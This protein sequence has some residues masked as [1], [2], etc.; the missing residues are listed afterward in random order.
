MI[1]LNIYLVYSEELENRQS[2]INSAISLVKDICQQK[3]VEMKLHIISEPGKDYINK[4]ISTF[5]SRVN[6][7]KFADGNLYNDLIMPLNVCQISNF[8]KHRYIYKLIMENTKDSDSGN[9]SNSSDTGIK[10]IHMIM[11]DD[12]IILKDYVNNIGML[13]DDLNTPSEDP[14]DDWDILFNCLNVVNNPEKFININQLYNIIISKS[15]YIIKNRKLCEKLYEATNTFKLNIKLTLSKF[16]KDNNYKAISYNKITFIEGSKLGLY[17]S[18]VNPNNYL[19]LNNN[20]ISLKQLSEKKELTEED[21]KNAEKIYSESLNIASIDIQ[22]LMGTIYFNYKDYKK[23]K[24]YMYT[25]LNNLKKC[26]GYSIMKNNEMLNNTINIY[27]Y[28]QDMLAECIQHKPKY[29]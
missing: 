14:N 4:H 23:A 6:Y 24:E 5:N 7:D 3:N 26:K 8:E 27:K 10:E 13:I 11:E 16:I 20:Y 17:P 28:D 22:S 21:I 1:K 29:S 9:S 2:T 19:F 25:S 18:A 15:C 12:L